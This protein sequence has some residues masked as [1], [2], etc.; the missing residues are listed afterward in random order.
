MGTEVYGITDKGSDAAAAA[1]YAAW[2]ESITGT[3]PKVIDLG[4][5][6][7]KVYLTEN[8]AALMQ[9]W[10]EGKFQR[11]IFPQPGPPPSLQIEFSPVVK[12]IA[13][14]YIVVFSALFFFTGWLSRGLIK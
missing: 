10:L 1:G 12:P 11:S 13:I 4:G 6:R 14:K 8:Q 2:V 9:A 5:G 3:L 7:A